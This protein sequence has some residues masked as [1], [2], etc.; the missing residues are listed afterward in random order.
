MSSDSTVKKEQDQ[1]KSSS[2][3]ASK[4]QDL[5]LDKLAEI[6]QKVQASQENATNLLKVFEMLGQQQKSGKEQLDIATNRNFAMFQCF[7]QGNFE[8]IKELSQLK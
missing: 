7:Y 2:S 1:Q 8:E 4:Q 5:D 6:F 3:T